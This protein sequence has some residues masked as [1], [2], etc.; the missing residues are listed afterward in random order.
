[1][2]CAADAG[3]PSSSN[4]RVSSIDF[5]RA[6]THAHTHIMRITYGTGGWLPVA[7]GEHGGGPVPPRWLGT[8][9]PRKKR[10]FILLQL[11][12]LLLLL[13]CFLSLHF[14][15]ILI[16]LLVL[17]FSS[18]RFPFMPVTFRS[19]CSTITRWFCSRSRERFIK[20]IAA[21][22]TPIVHRAPSREL[23]RTST[24]LWDLNEPKFGVLPVQ[25][26]LNTVIDTS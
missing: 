14:L 6:R 8:M 26:V 2:A 23:H 24:F 18:P 10:T 9:L 21:D 25:S 17:L 15:L 4:V 20:P 3:P 16:T 7:A 12:L 5:S 22:D 19:A 11:Y 1:M 13:F